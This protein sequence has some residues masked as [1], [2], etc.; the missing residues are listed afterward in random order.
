MPPVPGSRGAMMPRATEHFL[1]S[2]N[3]AEFDATPFGH[4]LLNDVL[5]DETCR[6][7]LALP[8]APQ[9]GRDSHGKRETN[10][11]TRIYFDEDRCE[12]FPVCA[13]VVG[14]FSNPRVI[15]TIER[16]CGI[17]VRGASSLRIEYTQDRDGFWLEPHTDVSVKR[18]TMLIYLGNSP[19]CGTDIYDP[20]LRWVKTAPFVHD[21]GLVFIPGT[22]TW[23]GFE[24]RPIPDVRRA[25]II[26][27][28][29][30]EWRDRFELACEV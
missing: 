17:Q 30:S 26:N 20:Q 28:V 5:P 16:T 22:D 3:R 6:D 2:W 12:Q 7:I 9:R 15:E 8:I 18:F 13:D 1:K 27:Y 19:G 4:W 11:D 25:L 10:N 14:V 24:R 29:T 21:H 23:H